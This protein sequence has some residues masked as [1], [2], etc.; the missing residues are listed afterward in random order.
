MKLYISLRMC[1][2]ISCVD[3]FPPESILD[4]FYRENVA[5]SL[6]YD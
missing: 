5:R 4:I 3:I 2:M 1:A 6:F